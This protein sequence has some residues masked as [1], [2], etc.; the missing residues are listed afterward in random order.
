MRCGSVRHGVAVQG[1]AGYSPEG[2]E[3]G[4]TKGRSY[5]ACADDRLLSPCCLKPQNTRFGPITGPPDNWSQ[6]IIHECFECGKEFDPGLGVPGP[7]TEWLKRFPNS[8]WRPSPEP[9]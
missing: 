7:G 5:L 9:E 3:W 1:E 8:K 6:T 4:T 2:T